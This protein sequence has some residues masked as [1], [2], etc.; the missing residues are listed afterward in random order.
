M[1]DGFAPG[2]LHWVIRHDGV[3]GLTVIGARGAH[4]I[5]ASPPV[6]TVEQFG[7]WTHLAVTLDGRS[8]RLIHY[9]NGQAVSQHDVRVAPPYQFGAAE[10]GNWNPVGF[11]GDDPFLSRNFSGVMDEFHLFGRALSPQE[12]QSLYLDGKPQ[13][14]PLRTPVN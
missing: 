2:T 12:I 8:R 6:L 4:Q 5:V 3:L 1:A 14:D 13:G 7:L 10:I 11:P 9:V